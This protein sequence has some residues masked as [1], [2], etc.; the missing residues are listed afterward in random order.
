[1]LS[2]EDWHDEWVGFP[3]W[4]LSD[5]AAAQ[6]YHINTLAIILLHSANTLSAMSL[7]CGW[8]TTKT[9]VP[10]S[11]Y[12]LPAFTFDILAADVDFRCKTR[13][14]SVT[15][16]CWMS[17]TGKNLYSQLILLGFTAGGPVFSFV[18][19]LH[20]SSRF[21]LVYRTHCWERTQVFVCWWLLNFKMIW[22]RCKCRYSWKNTTQ[23]TCV[24]NGDWG[25]FLYILQRSKFCLFL[26]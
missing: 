6:G 16:K 18:S 21:L 15:R 24:I 11:C 22:Y 4:N 26:L 14:C 23:K 19:G 9:K 8:T 1:M 17:Q 12:P 13:S 7:Q 5:P 3:G 20:R 25:T 2:I 10:I